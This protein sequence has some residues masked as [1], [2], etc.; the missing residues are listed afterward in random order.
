MKLAQFGLVSL[1]ALAI[2]LALASSVHAAAND[3]AYGTTADFIVSLKPGWNLVSV[4]VAN[5]QQIM[6][7]RAPCYQPMPANLK[8]NTCPAIGTKVFAFDRAANKY[9]EVTNKLYEEIYPQGGFEAGRSYWVKTASA[10]EMA[11][12]GTHR[13]VSGNAEVMAY[14]SA[15]L[16]DGSG[17][18]LSS[19]WNNVGAPIDNTEFKKVSAACTLKTLWRYNTA[20]RKWEKAEVLKPGEGYFVKL[21]SEC[22]LNAAPTPQ[23][24]AVPV[25]LRS[26]C[27]NTG[28]VVKPA[29]N[30]GQNCP[31]VM[32]WCTC[33]DGTIF[34]LY[35][36]DPA[37]VK[38][39]CNVAQDYCNADSDCVRQGNCCDCG[40]G[41]Y[42]NRKYA[43]EVSCTSPRCMCAIR[44]SK[45]VCEKNKCKAVPVGV[46]VTPTA[47]PTPSPVVNA[48][49]ARQLTF[50][51][52]TVFNLFDFAS[53]NGKRLAI[54]WKR[55]VNGND[56]GAGS[57]ES[58]DVDSGQATTLMLY[59]GMAY[60][61]GNYLAYI[62][63]N[64][65][66]YRDLATNVER[67]AECGGNLH[68]LDRGSAVIAGDSVYYMD[69]FYTGPY[70]YDTPFNVS[71]SYPVYAYNIITGAKREA[72]RVN[73]NFLA[74]SDGSTLAWYDN[75]YYRKTARGTP[76]N[77]IGGYEE[78]PMRLYV[79][80][81]NAGI[82][83]KVA[84]PFGQSA[85]YPAV[86]GDYVAFLDGSFPKTG[87]GS[88]GNYNRLFSYRIS[89]NAIEEI[90]GKQ[91][92]HVQ[93]DADGNFLAWDEGGWSENDQIFVYDFSTES[94][95]Q[96]TSGAVFHSVPHVLGNSLVYSGGGT[97]WKSNNLFL[98][99][100][101]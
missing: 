78:G 72:F 34:Q 56:F 62:E 31:A 23:P 21:A 40:L 49:P 25:D 97:D 15:N 75:E 41:K 44:E 91:L 63:N 79:Y 32:P 4:P 12:D 71:M 38:F 94:K 67:T 7:V 70:V 82:V 101:K 57:I 95:R 68:D 19:G 85:N 51:K 50:A 69:Q 46:T 26:L 18:A 54:Y 8:S 66:R 93:P 14:R 28:G 10:C 84:T 53:V 98:V 100:I 47:T 89:T 65:V 5:F 6:C 37:F 2:M 1:A 17:W 16:G 99:D 3:V 74:A 96:I 83:T 9:S 77:S 52:D 33:S 80:S 22:T 59:D 45:G 48:L 36:A 88:F 60:S 27:T 90:D 64:C 81:P 55:A 87:V 73:N 39:G 43:Q 58:F 61:N 35:G 76:E 30:P 20:A 92:Y 24:T 42:V 13:M 86:S 29:C 11:F